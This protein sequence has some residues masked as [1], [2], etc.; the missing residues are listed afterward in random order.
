MKSYLKTSDHFLT[1]ETFELIYDDKL[2]MLVTTPKPTDLSKYYNSE[3]YISHTDVTHSF[4]ERIYARIKKVNLKTKLRL[5]ENQHQK[6]GGLLDIGTGTGD[7]IAHAQERGWSVLGVEPNFNARKLAEKKGVEV[8]EELTDIQNEKFDVIT[9]WHVLEHLPNLEESIKKIALILN[10]H[11]TLII[12]VPNY[13]SYD[14]NYY[15]SFWAAYDVPRHLWHFSKESIN[16]LF[17][18]HNIEVQN[19]K[20]MWFD[21]FYVSLLSEEY[22]TGHKNWL[23]AFLL[24]LY[25]NLRGIATKEYSSHIYIL[26]KA[27]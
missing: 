4:M 2:D 23:K 12:A 15:K 5:I 19:I 27:I 16:R 18:Q 20:P 22:K 21:S 8:R 1:K 26:K 3:A 25:S 7:F 10:D 11:G 13:R 14:A 9:L 24:G 17:A 6:K